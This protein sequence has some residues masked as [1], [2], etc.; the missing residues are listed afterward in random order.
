MIARELGISD[1]AVHYHFPTKQALYAALLVEPDYGTLP[2]DHSPLSR[3]S[4]LDQVLAMFAWWA[5]RPDL[6]QML[7]REQLANDQQSIDFLRSSDETWDAAVTQPMMA[8][9][10]EEGRDVAALLF[11][12]L[13]GV[14]WD[15]ILTYRD[16]FSEVVEQEYFQRRLRTMVDLAIPGTRAGESP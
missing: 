4:L 13:A 1:P 10:G 9:A 3:E 15:A 2:L 6:G 8:F 5:A 11:D 14:F 16:N 12:M 7:L